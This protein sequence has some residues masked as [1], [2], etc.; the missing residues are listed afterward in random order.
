[1][2][3]ANA[4][5]VSWPDSAGPP[6]C[7]WTDP[8]VFVLLSLPATRAALSARLYL[9]DDRQVS[10]DRIDPAT[11]STPSH[12]PSRSADSFVSIGSRRIRRARPTGARC[13]WP[14][15]RPAGGV[16]DVLQRRSGSSVVFVV[17]LLPGV[18]RPPRPAQHR[19]ASSATRRE[20]P[21]PGAT[22]RV[23]NE[24]TARRPSRPSA[25]SRE[26]IAPTRWRRAGIAWKR[27]STGSRP[28]CAGWCSKPAR[29]SA[30][31]V[32]LTP[33]RVTEGV[34]VT[35]RRDRGSGAGGADSGVGRRAAT[36][37]RDAG[38]FNVNRLKEL[39]PT[40]QFYSTN[41]RN[42][43]VNIRGLGAPF[44]LTND[45]IEAGR[46]PLHRRRLLRA[47]R[48]GDARLPR[49]RAHRGAARPAGHA[50]R[51]EHDRRRDQR[52]D[53][54]AELHAGKPTSSSTTATS[55]SFR[56]RARSRAR[57]CRKVAG[58]LS[59]SGTQRGRHGP[60]TPGREN[61]V[62]DLNNLGRPRPAAVRAVGQA[63]DH[64]DRRPHAPAARGL[65]AGGRRRRADAAQPR[66]GSIRRSPP[67][68]ATPR[69]ASTPS[70]G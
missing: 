44:G 1:M 14:G 52:H 38:A 59:F 13:G 2:S 20:P 27:R 43:A 50:L 39:I 11:S 31:D 4:A 70:I 7:T 9:A 53:A 66:T 62:N 28:A 3:T 33:S 29:P 8:H 48:R 49:R 47:S 21:M 19:P 37:S 58:R 69:R 23:V 55:A 12:P 41:P 60:A 54:Q 26:P 61:D 5:S 22:V 67:I 10:R 30:I 46:R 68:S 40:V 45:G 57:S 18:S 34:V 42:S 17:A 51:Q 63:R 32:T 64:G 16:V 24:T 56:R 25:T 65:H 15:C 36:S 6:A 35:A